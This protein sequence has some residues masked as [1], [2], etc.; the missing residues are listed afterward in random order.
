MPQSFKVGYGFSMSTPNRLQT[1]WGRLKPFILRKWERLTEGDLQYI[2]AEFDRL[3]NVIK[4][5][6]DEP[7]KKMKEAEIR[8][9]LLK[10][11]ERVEE[12]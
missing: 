6:Y 5:R 12:D 1:H 7:I 3:V 8:F 10:M 2:D 4:E 9:E 11:I